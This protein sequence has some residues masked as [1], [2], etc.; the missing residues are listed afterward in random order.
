M[1]DLRNDP[2]FLR[3]YATVLIREAVVRRGNGD[4]SFCEFLIAGADRAHREA[5]EIESRKPAQ[6]DLFAALFDKEA[7]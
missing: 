5:L 2:A 1:K 4:N 3:H 6:G 7:A